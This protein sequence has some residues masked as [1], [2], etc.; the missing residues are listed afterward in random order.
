MAK[1][2]KE[3]QSTENESMPMFY[4]SPVLL[5]GERHGKLSLV[6]DFGLDFTKS[7]NAVPVNLIELPQVAHFYPIAFSNDGLATPV[8]I[9]GVRND[10]NLFVSDK[11]DW[12]K[13]TYIPSYIRRYPFILTEIN[14]GESLSLCIDNVDGV[15]VENDSNPLFDKDNKPTELS[16]NAMEF[17]KSYHSASMQTLEFSKA[18]ADSDLLVDR[19]AEL[20]VAGDKKISFSGFQIIDEEKF[21][22]LDEKTFNEWRQK[23]WVGAIYA[24]LFSG[25]HW[26]SI[27]QLLNER[28]G[29]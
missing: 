6:K 28:L 19:S 17:C 24:H 9:T 27:T 14:N 25:F 1:T 8:A 10:E 13:D 3:E 21:N 23:G 2:K 20:V 22:K 26:N 7:T 18:L 12:R 11:G 16:K 29:N 15:T 5:D 4:Q